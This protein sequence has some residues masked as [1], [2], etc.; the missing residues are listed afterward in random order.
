MCIQKACEKVS[1]RN[2]KKSIA[3]EREKD[4]IN[5]QK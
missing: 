5:K 1:F 3:R 2:E 4:E